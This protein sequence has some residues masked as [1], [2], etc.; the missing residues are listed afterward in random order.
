M[1]E[2]MIVGRL[3]D[4]ETAVR[5]HEA[6]C[7]I[8]AELGKLTEAKPNVPNLV[9]TTD[10]RDNGLTV[11]KASFAEIPF[12]ELNVAQQKDIIIITFGSPKMLADGLTNLSND[13][14]AQR[15]VDTPRFRSAFAELPSAED[16]LVFFDTERMMSTFR[17]MATMLE[18]MGANPNAAPDAPP[19]E[20]AMFGIVLGR[21]LGD[22]SIVD[23]SATVEWTEGHRVFGET[24][25]AVRDGATS[26]PLFKVVDGNRAVQDFAKYVPKE[27]ASFSVSSGIDVSALYDWVVNFIEKNIPDGKE[28]ITEWNKLQKDHLKLNIKDD[29]LSLIEGTTVNIS[30]SGGTVMMAKLTDEKKAAAQ[31]QQLLNFVKANIGQDQGLSFVPVQVGPNQ[32]LHQLSHPMLM[33]QGLTPVF[34]CADGYFI[35]AGS[36]ETVK[37]CLLTARGKHA[38][39]T[40]SATWKAQALMPKGAVNSIAFTNQSNMAQELQAAITS[41]TMGI[42]FLQIG[43]PNLPP[44]AQRLISAA[45]R[46]LPKLLPVAEKMNFFKSTASYTTYG[47]G[48]WTTRSVQNYKSPAEVKKLEEGGVGGGDTDSAM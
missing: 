26:S 16:K 19:S 7:A 32:T 17:G 45:A 43:A 27:A 3:K 34:G 41:M 18:K 23:Y 8:L 14:D 15:I 5:N 37:K 33:M 1:Y 20:Q 28:A 40:E 21:L 47:G 12:F 2:G 38:N 46:I 31:I 48:A 13:K 35:F 42:G 44:E 24:R 11:A 9:I 29:I 6:I 22:L 10:K 30:L 25:T 36:P 39:I 4:D